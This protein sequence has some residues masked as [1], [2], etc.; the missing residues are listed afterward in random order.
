MN[1]YKHIFI[2]FICH[3]KNIIRMP[4]WIRVCFFKDI[5]KTSKQIGH[6]KGAAA[7]DKY[8]W[9]HYEFWYGIAAWF[10]AEN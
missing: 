1:V 8:I 7:V 6:I 3:F 4:N 9:M 2:V 10:E 5:A